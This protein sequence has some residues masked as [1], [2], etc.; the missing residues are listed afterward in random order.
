MRH[1][2]VPVW[3]GT[4]SRSRATPFVILFTLEG[5]TR[6]TLITVIPLQAH[7]FLG[8]PQYVGL[9]F[10]GVSFAGLFGSFAVPW[11]VHFVSR[12]WVFT[13]GTALIVTAAGLYS[14]GTLPSLVGGMVAQVLATAC[15]EISLN[16]YLMDHVPRQQMGRFEPFRLVYNAGAW[17]LGPWLGVHLKNHVAFVAPFALVALVAVI[18]CGVFWFLRMTDDPGVTTKRKAHI[19]PVAYLRRYFSQPRLRL[20]W[21]L[22]SGRNAWW[23]LFFIYAPIYAVTAGFGEE[24]SGVITSTAMGFFCL[25][26]LWGWLGRRYGLRRLLIAAYGIAGLAA[27][28]VAP[29]AGVPWLGVLV[30]VGAAF[31]ASIVDGAGNVPFLRAVH[32]FERAEMTTVFTTYRH[33]G[34]LTAPAVLSLVLRVFELPAVFATG[35]AVLL[36]MSWYARHIPRRL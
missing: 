6:S 2:H 31:G 20:A 12:R 34:Q 24:T 36:A 11:L 7:Q 23:T 27:L 25:V 19:N 14:L 16:L 35:G 30:M 33:V 28:L 22:A 10:F 26:P 18:V 9:L 3:L 13:L 8:S 1:I 21:V 32:P 29:A 17:T 15:I 5:F 4:T